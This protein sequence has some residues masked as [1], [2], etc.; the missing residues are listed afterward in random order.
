[1]RTFTIAALALAAS[2]SLAGAA[3]ADEG[4]SRENAESARVAAE[5]WQEAEQP[6]LTTAPR[7]LGYSAPSSERA[8]RIE[9]I[10]TQP[11]HE[12]PDQRFLDQ[13]DR[14]LGTN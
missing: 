13:G 14:G 3:R 6:H 9:N 12:T 2:L 11:Q 10:F 7:A 1:M 4:V 5:S 8:Q